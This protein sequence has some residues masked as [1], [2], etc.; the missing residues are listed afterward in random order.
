MGGSVPVDNWASEYHEYAL[1]WT[2]DHMLF[3]VDSKVTHI[4][5]PGQSP[6]HGPKSKTKFYDVPYYWLLNTAVGQDKTWAGPPGPNTVLPAFHIIDYVR[7]A[8]QKPFSED[9]SLEVVV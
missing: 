6:T 1:E 3:L 2:K 7:V 5:K 9:V 4:V 8:Q